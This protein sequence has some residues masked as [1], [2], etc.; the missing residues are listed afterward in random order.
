M[1]EIA[2]LLG[3]HR[4]TIYRYL[5]AAKMAANRSVCASLRCRR[6]SARTSHGVEGRVWCGAAY[7]LPLRIGGGSADMLSTSI[8]S[9]D[10]NQTHCPVKCRT[11]ACSWREPRV[12]LLWQMGTPTGSPY[13]E[14]I[15]IDR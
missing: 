3:L 10:D 6:A 7:G 4:R 2:E 13:S 15:R 1:A 9:E 5:K 12:E 11:H 14:L 8:L